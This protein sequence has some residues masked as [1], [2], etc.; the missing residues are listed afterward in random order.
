[1]VCNGGMVM[2]VKGSEKKRWLFM[3]RAYWMQLGP[4]KYY[5]CVWL[6]IHIYCVYTC[7]CM[8]VYVC[9]CMYMYVCMCV[10]M[11]VCM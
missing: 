2:I 5:V 9:V 7:V 3:E 4:F 6:R 10:C 1:M 8:Y 11:Y